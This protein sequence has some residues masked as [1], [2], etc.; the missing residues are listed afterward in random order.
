MGQNGE[1]R[2]GSD[3]CGGNSPARRRE[4]VQG[5]NVLLSADF[6]RGV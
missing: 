5:T 2:K 1:E 4:R 6:N 3:L